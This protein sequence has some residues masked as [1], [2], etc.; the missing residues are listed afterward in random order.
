M[1]VH[2]NILSFMENI[3][4]EFLVNPGRSDL[5]RFRSVQETLLKFITVVVC[6]FRVCIQK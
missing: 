4:I 2:D 3:R 6:N 5:I 1:E